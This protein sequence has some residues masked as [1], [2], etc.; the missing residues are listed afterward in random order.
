MSKTK[1]VLLS[2]SATLYMQVSGVNT[3]S[4]P[5]KHIPE[6]TVYSLYNS[7]YNLPGVVVDN[8]TIETKDFKTPA[9]AL[10][11]ET[12]MWVARDGIWASS[13]NVRGISEQRL[14]FLVDN[15]RLQSATDIAGVLSTVDMNSVEK[16]EVIKG[17]GSV[18]YGTGAMGGVVNFISERP[19]YSDGY[20]TSGKI[21]TGFSSNNKLW[22]NGANVNF[23]NK[24]WYLALNGSYRTAKDAQTPKGVLTNSQFNDASWGLKGGIKYGEN[25]ELLVNYNHFEAWNVGIPGNN[26]FPTNASVRY[27]SIKRNQLS[28]E[29]IFNDISTFIKELRIKAYTQNISRDVANEPNATTLILPG[30][31]NTTSGINATAQLYFN[32]Y[33]TLTMGIESWVRNSETNR[34]RVLLGQDTTVITENPTPK[35]QML[36]IGIF[37]VYKKIIDPRHFNIN[38][39]GRLDYLRT[40][41]DTAFNRLR[42]YKIADGVQTAIPFTK[43]SIF[44]ANV[45]HNIS[46]ALHIDFDY[47]PVNKHKFSLQLA[48]SYRVAS[49]EER[50]KYIDLG[51][52]VRLGDP[53]LKP[54]KGLFS[55]LSYT[56]S[57]N[58]H[59]LKIAFFA[60]FLYDLIT[61]TKTSATSYQNVNIDQ[62]FFTGTELEFN[63]LINRSFKFETNASFV[64]ARDVKAN[65]FLPQIPPAHGIASINY[66][67]NKKFETALSLVWAATQNNTAPTETATNGYVLLNFDIHSRPIKYR[68]SNFQVFTGIDNALDKAYKNHLFS[69][70]GLDF[71]EPGRNFFAKLKWSW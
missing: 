39:G 70:R 12:G 31:L 23:T 22:S 25:Q 38:A 43:T 32:D 17:S 2:L 58:N 57:E 44:D 21:N 71:Y 26:A 36:D 68:N 13:V 50:F 52:G 63:W 40:T 34:M 51:N 62:A 61:E 15:D 55:N 5:Q 47:S 46:Y 60:N 64:Y 11:N 6:L 33:N 29:Y 28:G 66:F 7:Q 19:T 67:G 54:E 41:N 9:D 65:T 35:A 8:K 49:I 4:I 14:L 53:N 30:S 45:N 20:S 10:Q 42:Y 56:L 16:I 59:M 1:I 48:N 27:V 69:N 24:T 37:T 18:I 3:D